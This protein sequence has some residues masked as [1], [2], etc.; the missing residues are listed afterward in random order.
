KVIVNDFDQA[1]QALKKLIEDL[2]DG[3]VAQAMITGSAG[4]PRHG[5]WKVRVPVNQLDAFVAA[6]TRL[7]VPEKNSID[8][9][10]V[11]EEYYDLEARIKNKKVEEDRLL[12][13]LEKSTGKLEE[14][15]AVEREISRVRGEI[16]QHEGRLRLLANLT[17]L[18]TVTINIQEIKNYVP[19]QTPTFASTISTTFLGSFNLLVDF[20][21]GIFLLLLAL[22]PWLP[23]C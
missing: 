12:K 21:K 20:G 13:H 5:L 15:L 19:P 9:K 22:T 1:E 4:S 16:E 18:T 3:Y 23:V 2:K 10:D 11:T 14:I 8:S 17:A 6:V 7:G